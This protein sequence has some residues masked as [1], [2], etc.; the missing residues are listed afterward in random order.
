MY[1]IAIV[2]E[3]VYR[4]YQEAY[5]WALVGRD[6]AQDDQHRMFCKFKLEELDKKVTRSMA[7][8][9]RARAKDIEGA[10]GLR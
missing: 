5:A 9:A 4:D 8:A 2:H 1:N 10:L 3:E 6:N 7:A